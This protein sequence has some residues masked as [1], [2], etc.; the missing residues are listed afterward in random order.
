MPKLRS[1][2]SIPVPLGAPAH[3]PA[4]LPPAAEITA[5]ASGENFPVASR[6]LPST[7]RDELL[8][9][10][11]FARLADDIGD[12]ASGDRDA[13]LDWL[14][15]ELDAVYDGA[16]AHELM[17]RLVGPVHAHRIP[18]DPF[19]RL[20]EAN[21]QD[22]RVVRYE[23]FDDLLG[24][25][26]LSADPVG[27]LVLYLFDRATP[28]RIALSNRVCGALQV[29]EHLQDVREDL[30]RGRVYLPAE[31]MRRFGCGVEDLAGSVSSR[32]LRR[33]I[34]F[35]AA[36]A[37][38][39]LAAGAPLARTL[40]PRPALA[41]AAFTA[42]GEAVIGALERADHEVLGRTVRASKPR[43]VGALLSFLL[44]MAW[45]R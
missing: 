35:E 44:R 39:L 36:R 6:F 19:A 45:P 34:A 26:H 32:Q 24:Y 10:Y 16:P 3:A 8:A 21:R 7:L 2:D 1:A 27:E 23:T 31:D 30:E 4:D 22:Q 13:Q 40:P 15:R 12:E 9:L 33:L 38:S 42:G 20:I 41:V 29:V 14:E 5:K 17:R 18:R 25:C 43:R 37:R 28:E 11:G